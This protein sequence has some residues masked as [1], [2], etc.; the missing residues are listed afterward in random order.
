MARK[1]LCAVEAWDKR[2]VSVGK[3]NK[4]NLTPLDKYLCRYFNTNIFSL[5]LSLSLSLNL[6]RWTNKKRL[7]SKYVIFHALEANTNAKHGGSEVCEWHSQN[8][9]LA[10]IRGSFYFSRPQL[11][12]DIYFV[13]CCSLHGARGF[14]FVVLFRNIYNQLNWVRPEREVCFVS[15]ESNYYINVSSWFRTPDV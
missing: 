9:T 8:C 4:K 1:T 11:A 6:E 15:F 3:D 10:V 14:G 12:A 5:S 13:F 2:I 7:S